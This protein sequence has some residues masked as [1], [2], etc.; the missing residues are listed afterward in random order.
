MPTRLIIP[1]L[2]KSVTT[3]KGPTWY[4]ADK[5]SLEA[6]SSEDYGLAFAKAPSEYSTLL[7]PKTKCIRVEDIDQATAS[8][9]ANEEYTKA[10]F[11]LNYFRRSFPVAMAFAGN[12]WEDVR[13]FL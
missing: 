7:T 12:C 10:A 2:N 4:L 5:V 13:F 3:F 8:L 11:V 1:I 9:R 6:L